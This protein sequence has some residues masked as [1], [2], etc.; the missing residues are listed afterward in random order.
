M[1]IIIEILQT[2]LELRHLLPQLKLV[3]DCLQRRGGLSHS[4]PGQPHQCFIASPYLSRHRVLT[5]QAEGFN[6]LLSILVELS[7]HCF[8]VSLPCT[9]FPLTS[10]PAAGVTGHRKKQERSSLRSHQGDLA[11]SSLLC[12]SGWCGGCLFL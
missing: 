1:T 10:Y 9:S 11:L 4:P 12:A 3:W 2:L 6:S 5:A 8:F 7:L